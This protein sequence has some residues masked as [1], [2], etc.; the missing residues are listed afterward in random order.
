[1]LENVEVGGVL[2]YKGTIVDEKSFLPA[3][4]QEEQRVP[5]E[6]EEPALSELESLLKTNH[7]AKTE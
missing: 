3:L 1:M 4:A 2:R 5:Q 6:G 7:V